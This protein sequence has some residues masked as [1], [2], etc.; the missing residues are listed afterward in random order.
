[1]YGALLGILTPE[2]G[3]SASPQFMDALNGCGG[4]VSSSAPT[5]PPSPKSRVS[6]F[7]RLGEQERLVSFDG[8]DFA[9]LGLR[10]GS[11]V[12]F[13]LKALRFLFVLLLSLFLP[14]PKP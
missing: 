12:F 13:G 5:S 8:T 4:L 3:H 14:S 2:G 11:C 1:M 9:A 6:A 7:A 10:H